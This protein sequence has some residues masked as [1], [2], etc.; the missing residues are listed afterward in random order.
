MPTTCRDA[1]RIADLVVAA[2]EGPLAVAVVLA[3]VAGS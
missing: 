2:G 1:G 3:P